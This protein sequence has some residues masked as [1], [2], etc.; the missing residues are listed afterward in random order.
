MPDDLTKAIQQSV[1]NLPEV[2]K[3]NG[4]SSSVGFWVPATERGPILPAWGTRERERWLRSYDRHELNNL[5]QGARSGLIKKIVATPFELTGPKY[6]P[7]YANYFDRVL[8]NANFR[9]TGWDEFL[10]LLLRDFLRFDGG[11]YFEI[12]APGNPLKP[13]TGRITG[14]AHLDSF[15][16]LP[17]GDPDYPVV[18]YNTRPGKKPS[19]NV[20]HKTRV[21][22]W[23]DTPDGDTNNPGYGESALSRAIALV[24][25][26]ILM[27]RYIMGSLDDKPQPGIVLATGMNEG[28]WQRAWGNFRTQQSTDL[29]PEWGKTLPIFSLDPAMPIK[30]ENFTF[31]TPPEKFDY[32]VYVEIDI[33][34]LALAIGIDR[35][36]IAQLSGGNIGSAGQSQV[37]HAKSQGKMPG[38]IYQSLER[39][40]NQVLPE[41]CEFSFKVRD[42]EESAAQAAHASIWAGIVMQLRP[43]IGD[44]LAAQMLTNQVE[45]A[46]D[47]LLDDNGQLVRLNDVDVQPELDV[48]VNDA[49]PNDPDTQGADV[50]ASDATPLR[51]VAKDFE[52][53]VFPRQETRL[54]MID[55]SPRQLAVKDFSDTASTFAS[56]FTDLVHAGLADD[57]SRRRAG[58]VMRAILNSKGKAAR[59]EGLIAGGVDTGLTNADLN[60]HTVW[61]ARNSEYVSDFLNSMYKSGLSDAQVSQHADMW[62]S[63]SL[64]EAYYEGVESADKNGVY[65]FYGD[66]GVESCATCSSLKG[67]KMRM[68]EW[69]EKRLRPRVDTDAYDCGGW[70]CKHGIRRVQSSG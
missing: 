28:S 50:T 6:G 58:T 2:N 29:M 40:L 22:H 47:A 45:A 3:S 14:V 60:A 31:T 15:N 32:K 5:W 25:R 9:T 41:S 17:T 69:T 65:E 4:A 23:V 13:P 62:V 18:Y 42:P 27:G 44:T 61:L 56:D 34:Q 68:S 20:L 46:A 59:N 57:I 66:D 1:Q 8:R 26:E 12:I 35:Q 37:L 10:S 33:D 11:A 55:G 21:F 67:T 63:K 43:L 54:R 36:E 24:W 52:W 64:T 49:A 16:C 7:N 30:L 53:G 48:T 39:A 70:Q 51:L 19:V 38:Y